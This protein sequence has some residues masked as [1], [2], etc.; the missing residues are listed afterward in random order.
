M[1]KFDLRKFEL[2]K[3]NILE[4]ENL[5]M[6]ILWKFLERNFWG[7]RKFSIKNETPRS[8]NLSRQTPKTTQS[9]R[10]GFHFRQ[11]KKKI[12]IL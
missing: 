1:K 12:L 6:K 7:N 8:N 5:L 2:F 10:L 11:S 4:I 3:K 9:T